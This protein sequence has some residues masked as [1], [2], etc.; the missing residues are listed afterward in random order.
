MTGLGPTPR[1]ILPDPG[2]QVLQQ[3]R[4]PSCGSPDPLQHPA[5]QPDP[6][7]PEAD[8]DD[9]DGMYVDECPDD[10]HTDHLGGVPIVTV[11]PT[12]GVL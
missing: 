2:C 9:D 6:G 1:V 8:D 11:K 12:G 4:C 7:S 3:P 10:Y 5:F